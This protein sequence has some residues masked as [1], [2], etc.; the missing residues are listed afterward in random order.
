MQKPFF[1]TAV[2]NG[3]RAIFLSYPDTP[4]VAQVCIGS[5]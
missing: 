1:N 3:Y 4:A 2:Q 5:G